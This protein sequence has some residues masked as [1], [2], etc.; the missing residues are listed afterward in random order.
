MPFLLHGIF[1]TFLYASA[2]S[3]ICFWIGF[4]IVLQ[5]VGDNRKQNPYLRWAQ[6]AILANII[7]TILYVCYVYLMLYLDIH[8]GVGI[9][10]IRFL[11]FVTTPVESIFREIVSPPM[12]RLPD[13]SIQITYTFVRSL[14][15][16]FFNL[17]FYAL[18]GMLLK[19]IKDKKITIGGSRS[20]R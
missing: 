5:P 15:T 17:V 2:P 4:L 20:A 16:Q 3:A 9:D 7:L 18:A 8:Q 14:L 12:K 1:P 6:C 19:I 11:G 10:V 13:G